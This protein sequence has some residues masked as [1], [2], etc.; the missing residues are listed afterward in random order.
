MCCLLCIQG[1]LYSDNNLCFQPPQ[2][3]ACS[4]L[5]SPNQEL[6]DSTNLHSFSDALELC[7]IQLHDVECRDG[8]GKLGNTGRSSC[9]PWPNPKTMAA[10]M[11]LTLLAVSLQRTRVTPRCCTHYYYFI[12]LLLYFILL[13]YYII[14]ILYLLQS[15]LCQYSVVGEAAT[16]QRGLSLQ[17]QIG[18]PSSWPETWSV[19]LFRSID[20]SSAAGLPTNQND[21]KAGLSSRGSSRVVEFGIQVPLQTHLQPFV[22]LPGYGHTRKTLAGHLQS[23]LGLPVML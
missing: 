7:K 19:Q 17:S 2:R 3:R 13:L 4:P 1:V 23:C 11:C 12:L 16:Q 15:L 10:C 5:S 6:S 14:T 20:S 9:S 21:L 18:D 22:V 8:E